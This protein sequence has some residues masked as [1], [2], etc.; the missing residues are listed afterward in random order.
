MVF[1]EGSL[2]GLG[3]RLELEH[4]EKKDGVRV[5]CGNKAKREAG[6]PLS[7]TLVNCP[8]IA[9]KALN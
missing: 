7:T 9:L 3:H 6:P 1:G 4:R 5:G 8:Y 2:N